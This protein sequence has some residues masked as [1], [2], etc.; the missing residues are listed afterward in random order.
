MVRVGHISSYSFGGAATAARRLHDGLVASG[1]DSRFWHSSDPANGHVDSRFATLPVIP[2]VTH[3][4]LKPL[5][6]H[7]DKLSRRRARQDWRKHLEH[8]PA[9]F[10]VFSPA[11]LFK[12]S[13]ADLKAMDCDLLHLHWVAFLVDYPSFFAS[14]PS[15]MPI[16]WTLH[17]QAPFTGGCHYSSGCDRFRSG[18]GS[19]PQVAMSSDDD[20]SKYSW[21]VKRKALRGHRLHVVTPSRWLGELAQQSPLWP[22][23]TQFSVIPYGLDLKVHREVDRMSVRREFG[24]AAT[25]FTFVFGAEDIANRRKG[26]PHLAQ[27]LAQLEPRENWHALVFGDGELPKLP[28]WLSVHRLGY[29]RDDARKVACLSA[30]DVF[31]LPSLED[32]QPQTGLEALACGT[33]VV[34]FSAGGIPEYVRENETGWLAPTGDVIG[35]ARQLDVAANSIEHRQALRISSRRMMEREFPLELQA[36]RMLDLYSQMLAQ[37]TRR[38]AA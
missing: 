23:T 17:D 29:V 2:Q 15:R 32:N 36:E 21:D 8:R 33:P 26:M 31:V 1:I 18:C 30:G 34:A 9:G 20:V 35:L 28:T 6:K 25:D 19:C 5:F 22:K 3:P 24:I 38:K 16:V 37:E 7:W 27:A 14:I 11:Q 12:D 4:L 13:F 10:E